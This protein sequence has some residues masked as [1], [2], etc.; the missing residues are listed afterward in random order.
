MPRGFAHIFVAVARYP[1]MAYLATARDLRT[2]LGVAIR[3]RQLAAESLQDPDRE[4][5]L[6]AAAALEARAEWLAHTLPEERPAPPPPG[7]HKPIDLFV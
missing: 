6:T 5:F 3:L 4:L 7:L 1:P 2:M